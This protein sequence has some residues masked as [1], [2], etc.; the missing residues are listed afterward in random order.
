MFESL[1]LYQKEHGDTRVPRKYIDDSG[2]KLGNW[3][4]NQHN[5]LPKNDA[6]RNDRVE[7]LNNIQFE[8]GMY[9]E[10]WDT[11][12]ERLFLYQKEH[13]DTRVPQSYADS[14]G[15]NLG[16]WVNTQRHKLPKMK[17]C[18]VRDE[19]IKKL[20]NIQFEWEPR[21]ILPK[22]RDSNVLYET[23]KMF[24]N[25]Q[26]GFGTPKNNWDAMFERL[27]LYKKKHGDT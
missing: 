11:I 1:L 14:S 12:F 8:W 2:Y 21:S 24:N 15:Y 18:V 10:S 17:D 20:N 9:N 16:I 27:L 23:I 3:A 26:F 6:V 7:K 25:I 4:G 5:L 19:R 13:G 22:M